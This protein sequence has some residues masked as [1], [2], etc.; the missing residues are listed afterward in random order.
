MVAKTLKIGSALLWL[1][2]SCG[3]TATENVGLTANENNTTVLYNA[4][5]SYSYTISP[6][7]IVDNGTSTNFTKF[8]F[9]LHTGF[10][11]FT[12]LNADIEP[13]HTP[14]TT[15]DFWIDRPSGQIT[16]DNCQ[17]NITYGVCATFIFV[18]NATQLAQGQSDDGSCNTFLS[19]ECILAFE[20]L[21]S[22]SSSNSIESS[23]DYPCGP[24]MGTVPTECSLADDTGA[25]L[26]VSHRKFLDPA[27]YITHKHGLTHYSQSL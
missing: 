16:E 23:D 1:T 24:T 14:N 13:G 7:N 9:T 15:L 25:Q 27:S 6:T 12:P 19:N 2:L 4:T 20:R 21:Y 5:S 18:S 26:A 17:N 8:D 22:G 3:A 10:R 11:M